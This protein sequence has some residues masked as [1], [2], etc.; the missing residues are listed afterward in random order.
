M[1]RLE[2]ESVIIGGVPVEDVGPWRR[3]SLFVEPQADP[4][5]DDPRQAPT[6]A[7]LVRRRPDLAWR[8]VRELRRVP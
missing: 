4:A 1:V 3:D 2:I 7:R 6:G 8:A 5:T